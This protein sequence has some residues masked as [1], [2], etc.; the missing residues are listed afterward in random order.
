M[1]KN[2]GSSPTEFELVTAIAFQYFLEQCCDIIVLEVGL[3]GR[4]DST[5]IIDT[6]KAAVITTIDY[7]HMNVLGNTIPEIA[8]ERAG[9]IKEKSDNVLYSQEAEVERVFEKICNERN[10]KLYKADF[11]S[12]VPLDFNAH[13]QKFDFGN[14][15]SLKIKLLD[16]HQMK[17]AAV[18]VITAEVLQDKGF[19]ITEDDIRN[20][21]FNAKWPGRFEIVNRTPLVIA[22]GSHNIQGVKIL[23]ENIKNIFQEKRSHLL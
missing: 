22:D 9:I 7:D 21:L 20:G 23:A 18:S 17:N 15:K 13:M 16:E 11:S 12:L 10:A 3:G 1:V 6:P 8:F 4:L 14:Y 5:N 19:K 2:S